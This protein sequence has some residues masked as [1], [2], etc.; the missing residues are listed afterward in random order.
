[1]HSVLC[2]WK[3]EQ[4]LVCD[5]FCPLGGCCRSWNDS[6]Q[7]PHLQV[8]KKT[9]AEI[10]LHAQSCYELEAEWDG[11]VLGCVSSRKR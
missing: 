5:D 2:Y 4:L 3:P 9:Y 7:V 8:F 6:L 1:M 10:K 11:N